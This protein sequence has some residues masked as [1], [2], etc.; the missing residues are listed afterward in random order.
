VLHSR[1]ELLKKWPKSR[2]G[3]KLCG[4]VFGSGTRNPAE[5]RR[6]K[7]NFPDFPVDF[8]LWNFASSQD[9]RERIAFNRERA[10][11]RRGRAPEVAVAEVESPAQAIAPEATVAGPTRHRSDA[12]RK[13]RSKRSA[14]RKMQRV[15][16]GAAAE[17]APTALAAAQ[18]I[19]DRCMV[20]V[21]TAVKSIVQD[22]QHRVCMMSKRHVIEKRRMVKVAADRAKAEIRSMSQTQKDKDF[23]RRQRAM[24]AAGIGDAHRA[25]QA[26]Q[27]ERERSQAE[28]AKERK[29]LR[30]ESRHEVGEHLRMAKRR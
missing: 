6:S 21:S 2:Q 7:I 16:D 26:A 19:A 29:R 25:P 10:L 23:A 20:D 1:T 9:Q 12:G 27:F 17:V 28:K 4:Q 5:L 22:Q 13:Q 24:T 14:K 18:A 30:T 15:N 8:A 11:E 3:E